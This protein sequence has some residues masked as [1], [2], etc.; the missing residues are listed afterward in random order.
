MNGAIG[1]LEGG[2]IEVGVKLNVFNYAKGLHNVVIVNATGYDQC[3]ASPNLG[4]LHTGNDKV[5]LKAPGEK[6]YICEYRCDYADQK[7]KI[8]DLSKMRFGMGIPT[9]PGSLCLLH[10]NL[11]KKSSDHLGELIKSNGVFQNSRLVRMNI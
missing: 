5:A 9:M 10:E 6:Y 8:T 11:D 7:L 3:I 2:E 1:K 4:V